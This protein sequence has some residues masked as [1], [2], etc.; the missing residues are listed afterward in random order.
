MDKLSLSVVLQSQCKSYMSRNAAIKRQAAL[1]QK[2][3]VYPTCQIAH[4]ILVVLVEFWA[5]R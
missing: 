4:A 1:I 3:L 2:N 5:S